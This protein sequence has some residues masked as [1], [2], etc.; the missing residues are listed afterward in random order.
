MEYMM[1]YGWS[2]L[3]VSIVIGILFQFG[4]FNGSTFALR[5][6]PGACQVARP[7]GPSTGF[8]SL[9]GQCTN[10]LPK[11]VSNFTNPGGPTSL[12]QYA[13]INGITTAKTQSA[14]TLSVWLKGPVLNQGY[15]S[16]FVGTADS[17]NYGWYLYAWNLAV[18]K[19]E[20][21][22]MGTYYSIQPSQ[23]SGYAPGNIWMNYIITWNS[24]IAR[25][26]IGYANGTLE[27]TGGP[28]V[29]VPGNVISGDASALVI[30]GFQNEGYGPNGQIANI[31]LYNTSLS[32]SEVN[33]IYQAGV[34]GDPIRLQNLI[35]WW[36]LNSNAKDYSGNG[37]N[38]V[39]VN[40]PYT[41]SY[42]PP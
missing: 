35:G 40:V 30:A 11:W 18:M 17:S 21:N 1:T 37:N 7:N 19:F 34:G 22:V 20:A 9:E 13:V 14:M 36:P 39:P 28:V 2:I 24:S 4:L 29:A 5:A 23:Q 8:A 31:Q 32:Q 27:Q 26:I 38:G 6:Q 10:E 25:G 33:A 3:I 42:T 16:V 41:S 15:E 12:G